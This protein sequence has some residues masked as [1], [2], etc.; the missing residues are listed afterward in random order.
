MSTIVSSLVSTIANTL[1]FL[2]AQ[3]IFALLG[4]GSGAG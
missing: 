2:L 4:F 3:I 1:L